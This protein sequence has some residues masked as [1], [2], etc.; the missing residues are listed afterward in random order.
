MPEAA[1]AGRNP[2]RGSRLGSSA[3]AQCR[4]EGL[5][6]AA[7]SPLAGLAKRESFPCEVQET[8]TRLR[9]GR[10]RAWIACPSLVSPLRRTCNS[11]LA[12]LLTL[13]SC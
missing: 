6:Q 9:L 13:P 2:A 10:V 11:S 5:P 7:T 1:V 4:P 8:T 12:D 3:A